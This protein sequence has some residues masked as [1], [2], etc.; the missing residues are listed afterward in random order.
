M[1]TCGI[2]AEYNPFHQGHR[3][4]LSKA[5]E[6]SG[7]ET[8]VVI[9]S[10][11][12]SQRGLPSLMD[13]AAK[14]RLALE[15]GA[16][17]VLEL[18]ACYTLQSARYFSRYAI[19]SLSALG[20]DSLCFG[21]ETNDIPYLES[22]SLQKKDLKTDPSTSLNH[23]TDLNLQPNDILAYHYIQDCRTHHIEP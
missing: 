8:L 12:F 16:D 10:G 5:K 20:I 13:P 7:C 23:N 4:H 19:Q 2:I 11:L 21:S 14:T 18:P 9:T 17:L 6:A 15:N 22:L 3:Y 1:K